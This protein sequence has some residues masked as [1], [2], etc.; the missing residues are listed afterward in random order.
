[1][2]TLSAIQPVASVL[3]AMVSVTS[4][5]SKLNTRPRMASGAARWSP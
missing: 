2:G 3:A 4:P 5:K 1:M